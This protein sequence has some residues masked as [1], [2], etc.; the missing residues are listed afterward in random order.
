LEYKASCLEQA[1]GSK[2][3]RELK[4]NFILKAVQTFSEA[5]ARLY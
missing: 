4:D 2:N 5:K 3:Q 1:R